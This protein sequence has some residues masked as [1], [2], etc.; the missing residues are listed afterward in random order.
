MSTDKSD[1]SDKSAPVYD[2]ATFEAKASGPVKVILAGMFHQ[3]PKL[4]EAEKTDDQWDA[5]IT[6]FL[7]QTAS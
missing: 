4:V 7:S 2:G 1:K 3:D 6:K 5:A